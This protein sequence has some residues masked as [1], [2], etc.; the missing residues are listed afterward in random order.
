MDK[1]LNISYCKY[2]ESLIS[3]LQRY[4]SQPERNPYPEKYE[5]HRNFLE[6]QLSEISLKHIIFNNHI[7]FKYKRKALGNTIGL[8]KL[9]RII[10]K[11]IE[12][13][14]ITSSYIKK[15]KERKKQYNKK[16]FPE[17][18]HQEL[19]DFY[20]K[21]PNESL[22]DEKEQVFRYLQKIEYLSS[23]DMVFPYE[24]ANKYKNL[25]TSVFRDVKSGLHYVEYYGKKLFFPKEMNA[26]QVLNSYRGLYL[27]QDI[28]SPHC[29]TDSSF[30]VEEG[31]ICLDI[32]CAEGN[33]ALTNIERV[34]KMYLFE[35]DPKWNEALNMTFE[36]WKSKVEII[37]KFV[38]D[39]DDAQ[40]ISLD[41][42][43]KENNID[44]T[45]IKIDAEGAEE[46]I[47]K[48][49]KQLLEK[50][51]LKIAACT[52]H[53]KDDDKLLSDILS[54]A[55]FKCAFSNGYMIFIYDEELSPPYLRRGLVRATK[56]DKGNF[57]D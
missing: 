6:E 3:Q 51:N 40:N 33:F 21:N 2:I 44:V 50:N 14:F 32:G 26:E 45:F 31:D 52:Y 38:S 25:Q 11:F 18:L 46:S 57:Q 22:D 53:R 36:P 39:K 48:G 19:L 34:K 10:R 41:T 4:Y 47:L 23:D 20:R 42:F 55:G 28:E 12:N 29:Y 17:L 30:S 35:T 56:T 43:T 9:E 24:F 1:F 16:D 15:R 8:Y 5:T 54:D 49:S 13:I 7:K 27:E 37:N